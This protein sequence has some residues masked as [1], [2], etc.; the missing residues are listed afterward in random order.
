MR[1]Y[2]TEFP[3]SQAQPVGWFN[4]PINGWGTARFNIT[5][6][7]VVGMTDGQLWLQSKTGDASDSITINFYTTKEV[8]EAYFVGRQMDFDGR[9]EYDFTARRWFIQWS[10]ARQSK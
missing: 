7:T 1:T 10:N 4:N 2:E 6:Y 8:F 5:N 9:F 3:G